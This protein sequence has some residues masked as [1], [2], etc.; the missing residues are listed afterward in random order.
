MGGY[1]QV[2]VYTH[3]HMKPFSGIGSRI[4]APPGLLSLNV[5]NIIYFYQNSNINA[6]FGR[7][8]VCFWVWEVE[9]ALCPG[10]RMVGRRGDRDRGGG[11][12]CLG[13]QPGAVVNS[14]ALAL[15]PTTIVVPRQL[16]Q[17]IFLSSGD[18]MWWFLAEKSVVSASGVTSVTMSDA[19]GR[20][21]AQM[22]DKRPLNEWI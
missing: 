22:S 6:F 7:Y 10:S 12:L 13:S 20:W 14:S 15:S 16:T 21:S 11:S 19:V 2:C 18:K 17:V 4:Y 5:K 3:R 9:C 1:I 8:T